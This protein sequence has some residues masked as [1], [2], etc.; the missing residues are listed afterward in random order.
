MPSGLILCS[1]LFS[2]ANLGKVMFCFRV[3]TGPS[4]G[5]VDASTTTFW[6]SEF[7]ETSIVDDGDVNRLTSTEARNLGSI[8]SSAINT[9]KMF[10]QSVSQ[11][12]QSIAESINR[13][14]NRTVN[15]SII[16]YQS[17]NQSNSQTLNR[18]TVK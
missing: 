14:I 5:S 9:W 16:L 6:V 13:T 12:V 7:T 11:S 10:T 2:S 17:I 4:A 15:Q 1:M 3:L 18:S 8:W